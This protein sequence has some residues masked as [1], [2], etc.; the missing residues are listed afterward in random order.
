MPPGCAAG[1][2]AGPGDRRRDGDGSLAGPHRGDEIRLPAAAVSAGTDVRRARHHARPAD[3][4]LVDA[5]RP[6][7]AEAASHAVARPS[8]V[9]P[10]GV[11]PPRAPSPSPSPP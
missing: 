8:G 11:F 10:P 9:L 2:R 3:A 1:T 5:P 4:G 6:L 7:V